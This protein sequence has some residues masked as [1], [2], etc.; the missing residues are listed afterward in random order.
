MIDGSA[1]TDAFT[2]DL[3]ARR[4]R[5]MIDSWGTREMSPGLPSPSDDVM[6]E[7]LRGLGYVE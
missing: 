1:L 6:I 5:T 3:V 7:S 2:D 4:G